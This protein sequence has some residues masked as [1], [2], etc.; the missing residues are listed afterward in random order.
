MS[1]LREGM[2]VSGHVYSTG[3][4]QAGS[5]N[6]PEKDALTSLRS[7]SITGCPALVITLCA[8]VDAGSSLASQT[9]DD[10]TPGLRRRRHQQE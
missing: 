2:L 7:L 10:G 9:P 1:L 8:M 5:E 6:A 4:R 3:T